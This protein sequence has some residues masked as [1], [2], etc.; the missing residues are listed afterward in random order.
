MLTAISVARQCGLVN[1][2]QRIY[3]GDL[4]EQKA[5]KKTKL[6]WKD[7]DF[8]DHSLDPDTLVPEKRVEEEDIDFLESDNEEE[9][10]EDEVEELTRKLQDQD[11]KSVNT[12]QPKPPGQGKKSQ[13]LVFSVNNAVADTG[14]SHFYR[15]M[16]QNRT[17][18]L[19]LIYLIKFT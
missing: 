8:S 17:I 12:Q 14:K 2:R 4:N 16:D 1:P 7:F 6:L 13:S 19:G 10:K 15:S 3:F 11:K 9:K 18:D 5:G